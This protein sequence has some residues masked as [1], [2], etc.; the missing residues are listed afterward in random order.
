MFSPSSLTPVRDEEEKYKLGEF[1][2]SLQPDTYLMYGLKTRRATMALAWRAY[3]RLAGD[4]KLWE[5][6]DPIAVCAVRVES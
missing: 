1:M 2:L 5:L 6:T 4:M 3:S